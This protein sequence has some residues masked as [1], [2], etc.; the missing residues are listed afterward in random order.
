M[1]KHAYRRNTMLYYVL[2]IFEGTFI[3]PRGPYKTE[4]ERDEEAKRLHSLQGEY[5]SIFR[6]DVGDRGHVETSTYATYE[7]QE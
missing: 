5:D 2:E 1:S 3:A 6:L 7:L 4:E